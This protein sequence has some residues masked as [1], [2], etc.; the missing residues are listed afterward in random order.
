MYILEEMLE[1]VKFEKLQIK[2][3]CLQIKIDTLNYKLF[4]FHVFLLVLIYL[5]I[6]Y[7]LLVILLLPFLK[8][9]TLT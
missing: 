9:L 6:Y 4:A 3:I 2:V 1:N 5:Q 8:C 7:L